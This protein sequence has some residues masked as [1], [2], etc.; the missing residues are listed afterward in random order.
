VVI[1]INQGNFT[2]Q[3]A[4]H[5]PLDLRPNSIVTA[6]FNGDGALDLA[7]H[8]GGGTLNGGSRLVSLIGDGSGGFQTGT[9]V[10]VADIFINYMAP[11]NPH[12]DARDEL[13]VF[14]SRSNGGGST[15]FLEV[16]S[17]DGNGGWT[18]QQSLV[19]TNNLSTSLQV[20]SVNGDA[21]PDL[22]MV[23]TV[24]ATGERSLR[25]YPGGPTGFGAEQVLASGLPFASFT[26]LADLNGDGLLD[27]VGGNTLFL[28]KPGGGHHPAQTI[29]I[30]AAGAQAVAD[31][32]RDGK[33]D[34]LNGLSILLQK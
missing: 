2:F 32:N 11:A 14:G 31:F 21:H 8:T 12:G 7:T 5:Y 23:Q 1:L 26:S 34:L 16:F 18:N 24:Q 28:A 9:P 29:W 20:I 10:V 19:F 25:V 13:V 17:V 6:D 3:D 27:V 33:A 30:G 4:G 15:T 22:V